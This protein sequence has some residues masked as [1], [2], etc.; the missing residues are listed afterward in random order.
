[1][2]KFRNATEIRRA[3]LNDPVS[4]RAIVEREFSDYLAYVARNH[5]TTSSEIIRVAVEKFLAELEKN[6]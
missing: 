4:I 1:M 6:T 5:N 2:Y 3:A